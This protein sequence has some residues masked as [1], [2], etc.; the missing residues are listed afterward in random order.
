ML[1]IDEITNRRIGRRLREARIPKGFTLTKLAERLGVSYQQL[2]KYESGV[3]SMTPG[4]LVKLADIL[5]VTVGSF[6]D[7]RENEPLPDTQPNCKMMH[8]IWKLQQLEQRNPKL[9]QRLCDTV[10]A[11]AKSA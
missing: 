5:G 8:L 3:N 10:S 4:K 11:I 1:K 9:F 6:F 2:Q 7:V